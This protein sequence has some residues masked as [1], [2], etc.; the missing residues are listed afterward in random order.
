MVLKLIQQSR[1]SCN[2][3]I[4]K[5]SNG[6]GPVTDAESMLTPGI[7]SQIHAGPGTFPESLPVVEQIV[8]PYRSWN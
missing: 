2:I 1:R 3:R 5:T 6:P 7:D 4:T 8:Y